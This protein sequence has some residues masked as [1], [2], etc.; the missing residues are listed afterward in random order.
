M[1][2][3]RTDDGFILTNGTSTIIAHFTDWEGEPAVAYHDPGDP[4][5][6][7]LTV[8]DPAY[9]AKVAYYMLL[10]D[11]RWRPRPDWD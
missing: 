4:Y 5:Y 7:Y 8:K 3:T 6:C 2:I 1:T 11:I 10:H 9:L